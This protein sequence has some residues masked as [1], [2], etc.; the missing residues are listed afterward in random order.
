MRCSTSWP[1]DGG[2]CALDAVGT[3]A[4]VEIAVFKGGC[5]GKDDVGVAGRIGQ[6]P[7]VHHG[8]QVVTEQP[9]N[10][11]VLVRGDGR[12]VGVVDIDGHDRRFDE[13]VQGVTE[14]IHVYNPC[15]SSHEVLPRHLG[16]GKGGAGGG[17]GKEPPS[18]LPVRPDKC[19]QTGDGSHGHGA[20]AVAGEPT[21]QADERRPGPG[22]DPRHLLQGLRRQAGQAA[23]RLRAVIGEHLLP[24]FLEPVDMLRDIIPVHKPVAH[25]DVHESEGQGAVASRTDEEGPVGGRRG[26]G[27]VGVDY[28]EP[29][30]FPASHLRLQ[31]KMDARSRRVDPPE[32]HQVARMYFVRMTGRGLTHDRLPPRVLRRGADGPVE[33]GCPQVMEEGVAGVALDEPHGPGVGIGENRLGAVAG[34]DLPPSTCD[35][36]K[37]FVPCGCAKLSRPLRS[38]ADERGGEAAGRMDCPFVVKHLRAEGAASVGVLRVA[39]HPERATVS[40]GHQQAAGV[41]AVIGADGTSDLFG[42]GNTFIEIDRNWQGRSRPPPLTGC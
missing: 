13:L 36:G 35:G 26:R 25:Q 15:G 24:Q 34:D 17:A 8:E 10:H 21:P 4:A 28:P 9:P 38:G 41:G 1:V 3:V 40:H 30:P 11:G 5:G 16:H 6:E 33:P 37:R 19:R 22:K 42:H 12:R 18:P 32:D 14:P 2:R 31:V 20:V 29:R 7:L 27:G 23:H 39:G